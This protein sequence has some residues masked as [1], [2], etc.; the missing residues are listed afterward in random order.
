MIL[1]ELNT[2]EHFYIHRLTGVNL[3]NVSEGKAKLEDVPPYD[4]VKWRYVPSDQLKRDVSEV[5]LENE[6]KESLVD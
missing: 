5:L 6:L 2:V 3:N 4:V 1:N